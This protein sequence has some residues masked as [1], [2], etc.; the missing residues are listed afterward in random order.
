MVGEGNIVVEVLASLLLVTPVTGSGGS[1]GPAGRSFSLT[2]KL[3][4]VGDH[5]Y[6]AP[7]GAI[8]GLPGTKLETALY[9]D[10]VPLRLVVGNGFPKLP[11]G[12]DIEEIHLFVL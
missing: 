5:V 10:G 1:A 8:L 2:E 3:D 9:K 6:L 4:V 12:R 7:L 11:P